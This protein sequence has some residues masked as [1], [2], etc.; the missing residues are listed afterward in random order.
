M[1]QNLIRTKYYA[2]PKKE[3]ILALPPGATS[4]LD[5]FRLDGDAGVL[6]LVLESSLISAFVVFVFS[7]L[8]DLAASPSCDLRRLLATV[9]WEEPS[10]GLSSM[11]SGVGLESRFR[12]VEDTTVGL[13]LVG[14]LW[15]CFE[16]MAWMPSFRLVMGSMKDGDSVPTL[17][18]SV[19]T[20]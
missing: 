7:R 13:V 9:A 2:L 17:P 19:G 20:A 10:L 11:F 1:V 16:I 15:L 4:A 18:T 5:G 6:T 12:F 14:E 8:L 3:L